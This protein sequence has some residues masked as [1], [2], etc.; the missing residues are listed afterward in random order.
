MAHRTAHHGVCATTSNYF[1]AEHQRNDVEDFSCLMLE[2]EGG[3]T[4]TITCGRSGWSSHPSHGTHKIHLTGTSGAVDLDANE[5]R[6]EIFNDAPPWQQPLQPH[7][8]DPMG[9]WSST[10]KAGG[11]QAKTA[12]QPIQ[13]AAV[14]DAVYF[15]DCVENNRSSDV[16]ASLGAHAV[17]VILAA[18][19]SAAQGQPVEIS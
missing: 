7:P 9:F 10:Q 13:P 15:L 19:R 4:A 18:Y 1:F 8:E 5:P 2:L 17:E 6:L 16:P 12:W 11:V 14:N 3:I